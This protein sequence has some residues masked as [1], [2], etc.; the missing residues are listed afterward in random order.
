[1][2]LWV[3][4]ILVNILVLLYRF[5]KLIPI[6]NRIVQLEFMDYYEIQG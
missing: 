1:M 3:W 5:Q 6:C 4:T 2:I